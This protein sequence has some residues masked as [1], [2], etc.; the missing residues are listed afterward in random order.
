M[1]I[2][3]SYQNFHASDALDTHVHEAIEGKLARFSDRLTRVEVHL[4][5]TNGHNKPG[6]HDKRCTLEARP[7]GKDPIVVEDHNHDIFHC[8]TEATAKLSRALEKKL[9]R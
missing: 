8:I 4:G 6:P 5:D 9:D 1:Q 7:A 3:I 2:K